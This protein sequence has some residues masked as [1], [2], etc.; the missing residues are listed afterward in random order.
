MTISD[1]TRT[2][3]SVECTQLEWM[4]TM[5]I[6]AGPASVTAVVRLGGEKP[7]ASSVNIDNFLEFSGNA[8]EAAGDPLNTSAA[9][10][11]YTIT[12][13]AKGFNPRDPSKPTTANFQ[14]DA[15]C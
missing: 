10:G 15:N 4:L 1:Q 5:G 2:T 13:T 12:G 3:H 9:G 14:I 6:H 11:K 7:V 8:V